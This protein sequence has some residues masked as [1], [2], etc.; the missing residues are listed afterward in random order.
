MEVG[1]I[2]GT[3]VAVGAGGVLVGGTAGVATTWV[4]AGGRLAVS[5][6]AILVGVAAASGSGTRLQ[7]AN[8]KQNSKEIPPI[9]LFKKT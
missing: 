2:V 7:A 8:S 1:S 5:A 3:A 9:F 4:G 6:V